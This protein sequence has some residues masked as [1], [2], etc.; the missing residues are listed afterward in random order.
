MADLKAQIKVGK[1]IVE[2]KTLNAVRDIDGDGKKEQSVRVR[3]YR[4]LTVSC[5]EK[6]SFVGDVGAKDKKSLINDYNRICRDGLLKGSLS[7]KFSYNL[8]YDVKL[9]KNGKSVGLEKAVVNKNGEKLAIGDAVSVR[10]EHNAKSV[11]KVTKIMPLVTASL[12]E[13]GA[14][15]VRSVSI[16][17][18]VYIDFGSHSEWVQIDKV[19]PEVE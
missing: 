19:S 3:S 7:T 15:S 17:C 14:D 9:S 18:E 11:G 5:G 2:T 13:P 6:S 1:P 4:D 10:D 16:Y 8:R 12:V